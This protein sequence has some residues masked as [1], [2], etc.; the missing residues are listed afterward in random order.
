MRR[1]PRDRR[2]AVVK[3]MLGVTAAAVV[4]VVVASAVAFGVWAHNTH[5][6]GWHIRECG[7][8]SQGL[9]YAVVRDNTIGGA[10]HELIQVY[11]ESRPHRKPHGEPG[12]SRVNLPT[13]LGTAVGGVTTVIHGRRSQQ[14]HSGSQKVYCTIGGH[15][16]NDYN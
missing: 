4:A 12:Y 1:L 14:K 16:N 11:F 13:I 6:A 3:K 7:F 2:E 8:D 10:K 15:G 9:P 5:W